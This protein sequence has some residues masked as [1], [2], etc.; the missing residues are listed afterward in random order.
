MTK[1]GQRTLKAEGV[2]KSMAAAGPGN[3]RKGWD[4]IGR[5]LPEELRLLEDWGFD[6]LALPMP[7]E[8]NSGN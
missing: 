7:Q 1:S 4:R 5:P 6:R 2:R 8:V 3:G